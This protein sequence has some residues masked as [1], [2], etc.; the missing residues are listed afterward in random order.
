MLK[1]KIMII[2]NK[3]VKRN[4][5]YVNEDIFERIQKNIVN[6]QRTL[7]VIYNNHMKNQFA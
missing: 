6:K 2:T 3:I 4:I 7:L 5:Y 1:I